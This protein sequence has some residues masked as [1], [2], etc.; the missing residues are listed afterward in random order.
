MLRRKYMKNL[1]MLIFIAGLLAS[2]IPKSTEKHYEDADIID[3]PPEII[4]KWQPI[5]F[6]GDSVEAKKIDDWVFS[7][8]KI[9]CYDDK[10]RKG[11]LETHFF[12][13]GDNLFCDTFPGD[14]K[15]TFPNGL[16]ETWVMHINPMHILTKIEVT[17]D[18]LVMI[19]LHIDAIW[20]ALQSNEIKIKYVGKK[21]NYLFTDKPSSWRKFLEKHG[22]NKDFFSEK[23]RYE[24]KKKHN[25]KDALTAPSSDK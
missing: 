18:K 5:I 8:D 7:K 22:E 17:K 19:P 21:D 12:K 1:L 15:S 16:N 14:P 4:G 23:V 25:E 11:I 24:F 3:P 20:K 6:F 10:K 9:E 2:C 13:I